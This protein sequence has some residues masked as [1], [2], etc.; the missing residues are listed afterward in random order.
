MRPEAVF[1]SENTVPWR[2]LTCTAAGDSASRTM[3][4][5]WLPQ[6]A[7]ATVWPVSSARSSITGVA[8]RT[9]SACCRLTLE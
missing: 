4:G 8:R 1:A 2:M 9:G 5:P 7:I 6:T 3:V